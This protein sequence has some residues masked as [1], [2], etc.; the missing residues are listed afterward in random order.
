MYTG[1][2]D[3]IRLK[4]NLT[5]NNQSAECNQTEPTGFEKIIE[6]DLTKLSQSV[7][8]LTEK[9]TLNKKAYT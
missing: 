4:N 3:Q 2:F 8:L 6:T 9:S 7:R 1:R 5:E